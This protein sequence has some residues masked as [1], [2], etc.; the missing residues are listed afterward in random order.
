MSAS[1]RQRA[2]VFSLS[3]REDSSKQWM[4]YT[5]IRGG[6]ALAF[7]Q[8][9]LS[10]LC[11]K[12]NCKLAKCCYDQDAVRA[13][14]VGLAESYLQRLEEYF[15]HFDVGEV[16]EGLTLQMAESFAEVVARIAPFVKHR[17]FDAEEEWRV[18]W[19]GGSLADEE[20][21][22]RLGSHTLIP[23]REIKFS[24][25]GFLK[26]IGSVWVK[27]S[28]LTDLSSMAAKEFFESE[29]LKKG[30][31]IEEDFAVVASACPLRS[32]L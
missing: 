9:M 17:D 12:T 19:R 5:S 8:K 21:K 32:A 28:G 24:S 4:G 30:L 10:G 13:A 1:K 6:Y 27:T 29:C 20:L 11:Q 26:A 31:A 7:K 2:Y 3:Q 14:L 22:F 16:N 15:P 25:F 18:V 23:Y